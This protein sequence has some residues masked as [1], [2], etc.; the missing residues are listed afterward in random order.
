MQGWSHEGGR[1][2]RGGRLRSGA[3]GCF[4]VESGL[5]RTFHHLPAVDLHGWERSQ[6]SR[7]EWRDEELVRASNLDWVLVR[8]P[9]LT[10]GARRSRYRTG[11]DLP[12]KLFSSV[13]R[14]DVA[15]F[16]LKQLTDDTYLRQAPTITN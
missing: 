4:R 2:G 6:V 8:P 16:M 15:E 13:S 7:S 11:T 9:L 14:A 10:N 12:I 3:G 5:E 1:C